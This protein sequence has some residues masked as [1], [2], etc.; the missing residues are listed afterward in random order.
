MKSAP[1]IFVRLT[2]SNRAVR[3]LEKRSLQGGRLSTEA[4]EGRTLVPV[5][6]QLLAVALA[7]CGR[8]L[9]GEPLPVVRWRFAR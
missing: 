7:G 3:P 6:V 2:N 4:F 8:T 1:R 9:G 5:N